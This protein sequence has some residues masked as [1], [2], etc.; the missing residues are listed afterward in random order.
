MAHSVPRCR[1]AGVVR[2]SLGALG[3]LVSIERVGCDGF[4]P[5]DD[6]GLA[7]VGDTLGPPGTTFEGSFRLI[8]LST[9]NEFDVARVRVGATATIDPLAVASEP[10]SSLPLRFAEGA[11][12]SLRRATEPWGPGGALVLGLTIGETEGMG[13][14][15][16]EYLRRAGLSHLVAVSGSNLAIVL[17]AVA[18]SLRSV[19]HRLRVAGAG[20]AIAI[21]VLVVGPQPSVL[22]A[23][24]MGAVGVAAIGW[25]RRTE[26]LLAPALVYSAGLQ[27]SAAATGGI[28]LWTG[29]LSKRFRALP[30]PLRSVLAASLSAQ[31]AVAPLLIGTFGELSLISPLANVLAFPPVAPATVLGVVAGA[32]GAFQPR[33]GVAIAHLASNFAG[34]ILLVGTR[35]GAVGWASVELPRWVGA[36]LAV[37]VVTVVWRTVRGLGTASDTP[38]P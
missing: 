26:P 10:P 18:F 5:V 4:A 31:F 15:S 3:A 25:G 32:L 11:R 13:E 1:G 8:P 22:R 6:P 2:E 30:G 12:A 9:R 37:P 35:L 23:A 27:L 21:F 34:W 38:I 7:A 14:T 33:A 20:L 36:L 24:A 19:G 17:G 16:I 28:V 29:P